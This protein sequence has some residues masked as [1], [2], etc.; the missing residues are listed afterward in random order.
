MYTGKEFSNKNHLSAVCNW[1]FEKHQQK[2]QI[3]STM[4]EWIM[5]VVM[6][7]KI[8]KKTWVVQEEMFIRLHILIYFLC[9]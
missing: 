3:K 1:K 7:N 9:F 4:Q 5:N 2:I 8:E 6:K